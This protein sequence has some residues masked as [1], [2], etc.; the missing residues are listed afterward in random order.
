MMII[1]S[2]V[3]VGGNEINDKAPTLIQDGLAAGGIGLPSIPG[4]EVDTDLTAK[5]VATTTSSNISKEGIANIVAVILLLGLIFSAL[6]TIVVGIQLLQSNN[7]QTIEWLAGNA[8][9][10]ILWVIEI[11]TIG[12][13]FT[14][15]IHET[16][17]RFA[18]LS[19]IITIA[20]LVIALILAM[21]T[22]RRSANQLSSWSIPIIV[23]AGLAVATYLS[24]VEVGDETAACGVIGDCNTV[25][26]SQYAKLFGIL[27]IGLMGIGGYLLILLFWIGTQSTSKYISE[28]AQGGLLIIALIGVAFSSYLTFL[29]PFVIKATCTWCLTSAA[30]MLMILWLTFPS[31]WLAINHLRHSSHHKHTPKSYPH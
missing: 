7:K 21:T 14:L 11:I 17:N 12:I 8:G 1:G 28:I 25:Q 24:Y 18:T 6:L 2:Q 31:G 29:E 20:S 4:L 26:Q 23:I 19:A 3:L 10:R 16:S 13:A 22:V 9:H 15:V 27:P 5:N 30:I